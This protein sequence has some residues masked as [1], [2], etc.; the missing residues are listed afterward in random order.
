MVSYSLRDAV[1][2]PGLVSLLRLPLALTFPLVARSPALAIT[3]LAAAAATDVADGMI[4]RGLHE[5]TP[6]GAALDPLM[7]KVFVLG[8]GITLLANGTLH[9]PEALL[10]AVRDLAELPLATMIAARHGITRRER[11]ANPFGKLATVLQFVTIGV[12][13][14]DGPLRK[15]AIFA[16]ALA[17]AVAAIS[18]WR[19]ELVR[20]A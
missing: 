7:D 18:Y 14:L 11:K 20:E 10:V 1:R 2:L 17:G 15:E 13:L 19:S 9:A 12:V 3:W 4:A 16:T 5:D 8:V 6:T